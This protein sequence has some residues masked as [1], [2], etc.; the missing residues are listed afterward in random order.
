MKKILAIA[1]L[2]II[3]CLTGCDSTT[4]TPKDLQELY[5][6]FY[7][8]DFDNVTIAITNYSSVGTA[9]AGKIT[10]VD[11]DKYHII[12]SRDEEYYLEYNS[13][14]VSKYTLKD[15]E[16]EI[17]T[18]LASSIDMSMETLFLSIIPKSITLEDFSKNDT[19]SWVYENTVDNIFNTQ[20]T[21]YDVIFTNDSIEVS[22][23]EIVTKNDDST[24]TVNKIKDTKIYNF[25]QTKV[26]LPIIETK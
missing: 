26:D 13:T 7:S 22:I 4:D 9:T 15:F 10:K 8:D 14:N 20:T 18:S 19:N 5:E 3:V 21:V 17:K 2:T 24:V 12:E 25:N 23:I 11:G 16:W 6:V 1:S